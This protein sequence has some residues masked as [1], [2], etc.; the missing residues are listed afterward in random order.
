MT[1]TLIDCVLS[2]AIVL[3]CVAVLMHIVKSPRDA[4]GHTRK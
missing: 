3:I 4:H 1:F 2:T